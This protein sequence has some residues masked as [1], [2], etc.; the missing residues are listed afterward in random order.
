[1]IRDLTKFTAAIILAP[2]FALYVWFVLVAYYAVPVAVQTDGIAVMTGGS[3]R[4]TTGLALLRDGY[5][6]R[7][8]ISGVA[9]TTDLRRILRAAGN[10]APP[11]AGAVELGFT[12][13][14]TAGNG[15]EIADWAKHR[16]LHSVMLVTSSYHMARAK[17]ILRRAA[18]D[19]IIQEYPVHPPG[20]QG[21]AG[22][23]ML[24]AVTLEFGKFFIRSLQDIKVRA[25]GAP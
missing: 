14:S 1:M 17:I 25:D 15:Q 23:A 22:L 12:A 6:P 2:V 9:A 24:P 8:L 18:P 16:G 5:A 21:F 3:D 19:L 20:M 7:L 4:I 13:A 11:P 10:V